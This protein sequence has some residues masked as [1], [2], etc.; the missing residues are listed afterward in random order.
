MF[1]I[2]PLLEPRHIAEQLRAARVRALVTL[3]PAPAIDLW[4]KLGPYL[5]ALKDLQ[6]VLRVDLSAYTGSE[7]I[8]PGGREPGPTADR[9]KIIDFRQA[10]QQQPADRLVAPRPPSQSLISSYVCT[11]GTTGLPKIAVRTHGNEVF[12]AWAVAEVLGRSATQRAFFCG[13]PLFHVN[14]QLVIG[15]LPWMQG[16]HVVLG[17]PQGY[18]GKDVIARFWDIASHYRISMFSGVPTLYA[19]L[20]DVPIADNDT[21][22]LEFGLCGAAP[23]PAKLIENFEAR[24]GI[25]ILEGYG[26]TEGTCVSAVNPPEGKRRAGSV[27]VRV[28]YQQ[29]LAV[30]L[31]NTG[32]F[33]RLAEVDEVGTLVI[34]GPNVFSGYLD[35]RHNRDLWLDIEGERWLNTGDLGRQDKRGFFW[36]SGRRKELIIR[37]GHNIDPTMIE[38]ALL[39]HPAVAMA[40]AIGS[41][42]AH[43]GEVPVAYVQTKPGASLTG[44][45]LLDFATAHIPERA[46]VP[47]CVN[48]APSLPLTGVG[49]IFKPALQQ[50]EIAAVV[51]TEALRVGASLTGV[52]HDRDSHGTHVLRI[53][54][55]GDASALRIA[56]DR[57]A[58]KSEVLDSNGP[59]LGTEGRSRS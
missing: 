51:R 27:G 30:I 42:D 17:T 32:L 48:I 50:L 54:A 14:A 45:D 2:N 23:M 34:K 8:Q 29:M 43:A 4:A 1:A 53:R 22:S 13:L 12:D 7:A 36:L 6:V 25:K 31:D 28:P 15:L 10:I 39:R 49:K 52:T 57:Y 59:D 47:K 58:F 21:S 35:A 56:L 18:R 46:A 38:D 24:T 9:F 44:Q 26:L 3:A 55:L 5:P 41:P 20:V 33:S 40:A 37:G 11:G 16:D 19:A